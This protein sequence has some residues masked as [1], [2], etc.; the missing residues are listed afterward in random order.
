MNY[1]ELSLLSDKFNKSIKPSIIYIPN[2]RVLSSLS[3]EK[4]QESDLDGFLYWLQEQN[5]PTGRPGWHEQFEFQINE[6]GVIILRIDDSF[7]NDSE[8]SDYIFK[9]GLFAMVSCYIDDDLEEQIDSLISYFDNNEHYEID[10]DKNG[11][12]RHAVMM[13]NLISPE[14]KRELVSLFVPA[15]EHF[16]NKMKVLY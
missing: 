15:K 6:E 8:Y 5:I 9:G 2:M 14:N 10:Y 16:L 13:E 7:I 4:P 3:K 1:K 11:S 12:L